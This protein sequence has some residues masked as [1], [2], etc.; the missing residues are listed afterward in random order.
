MRKFQF[1]IIAA[2]LLLLTVPAFAVDDF[3]GGAS[4][5]SSRPQPTHHRAGQSAWEESYS[6]KIDA[7]DF[8][9]RLYTVLTSK[10]HLGQFA[11]VAQVAE[12][13]KSLGFF[14]LAGIET[15][16]T[17]SGADIDYHEAAS[18][19]DLDPASFYGKFLALPNGKLRS[20]E[21]ISQGDYLLY[22]G[23]NNLPQLVMLEAEELG[24]LQN[25]A[26]GDDALGQA[27]A[28]ANLGDLDQALG[29]L[30]ALKLDETL[31]EAL[32]GEVALVL[33]GLP[34]FEKLNSGNIQPADLD[35][36]VFLGLN[37]VEF[38]DG[39]IKQF[40]GQAGLEK[41]DAPAGWTGYTLNGQP[42]VG[43]V[44]NDKLLVLSPNIAAA[45]EHI[46]AAKSQHLRLPECL[47]YMVVDCSALEGKVLHP[48]LDLAQKEL[49]DNVKLPLSTMSYLVNLPEPGALGNMTMM[50]TSTGDGYACDMHATKAQMQYLAYYLGVGLC[51]AAQAGVFDN[52]EIE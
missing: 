44:Y 13:M 9:Q 30:K 23:V 45:L 5:K 48:L 51:G 35:A 18:F 37:G 31:G 10:E 25:K 11:E 32:S 52:V 43:F 8:M 15:E 24:K 28:E 4:G 41:T 42:S 38:V 33:Y 21:M 3:Y 2:C 7:Q 27:L 1:A 14:N 36:A 6:L 20:A 40:G 19:K 17:I 39:L 46:K 34:E 26:G 50:T 49:G 29:M 47:Y 22:L 16:Y 12:C